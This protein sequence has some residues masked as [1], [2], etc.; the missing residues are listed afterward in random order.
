MDE[1]I[2]IISFFIISCL[3]AILIY[4]YYYLATNNKSI[5]NDLWGN[6]SNIK[7]LT[8]LYIGSMVLSAIGFLY[9]L[10][11]LY[12]TRSL[13]V[14]EKKMIPTS[15]MIIVIA[16]MV[17]MPLSLNYINNK[18]A[19][20]AIYLKYIIIGVLSIVAIESLYSTKLINSIREKEYKT[21]K[22]LAT[23]GMSYFFIHT[24]F[25]DNIYWSY[26]FF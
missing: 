21:E 23:I 4:S 10:Y 6:I 24:F 16:S 20:F 3:G 1:R 8:S 25:L 14:F 17:W 2:D 18:M 5:V 26:N 22:K 13:T 11:Y 9:S 19:D 7:H 12:I 15:L